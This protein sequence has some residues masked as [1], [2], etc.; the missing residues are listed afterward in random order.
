MLGSAVE[1][2]EEKEEKE[3][4]KSR[5][6][7]FGYFGLFNFSEELFGRVKESPEED[8]NRWKNKDWMFIVIATII[9]AFSC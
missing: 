8:M 5:R 4:R 2:E 7:R 6:R 3:R 9:E 1:K